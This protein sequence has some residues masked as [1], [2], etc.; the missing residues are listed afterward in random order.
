MS[1]FQLDPPS[2]AQRAGTL[3]APSLGQSIVHGAIGFTLVSVAGFVPWA[4]AGKWLHRLVGEAGMYVACMIVFI[5]L[6]GICL[7][8]LIIGRGS[9]ARFYKLFSVVFVAYSIAWIAGW[10]F[11]RGHLGSVVGLLAG[12]VIMGGMLA[13]AFDASAQTF[14]VMAALFVLNAIGYFVGG[15]LEARVPGI[16]G[17]LLWGVCYGLGF[18]A[19]LGLAF[20]FC[21]A[22]ARRLIGKG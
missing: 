13:C 2:L 8:R 14:K 21:Q 19:G 18:G 16:P 7:H 11:L 20:Y 12:T 15:L 22:E 5:A 17:K 6:A 3:P 10:M 9:L 1:W 4:V